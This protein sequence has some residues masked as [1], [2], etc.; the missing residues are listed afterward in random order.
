MAQHFENNV[1][2]SKEKSIELEIDDDQIEAAARKQPTNAKQRQQRMQ[3][4]EEE[5]ES[6]ASVASPA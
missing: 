6:E 3:R 1:S 4:V 2:G 5:A